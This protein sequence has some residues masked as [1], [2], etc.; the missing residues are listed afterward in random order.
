MQA[1]ITSH[2]RL[3]RE[4]DVENVILQPRGRSATAAES[5]PQHREETHETL[6]VT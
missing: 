3:L 6:F 5:M 2:P 1:D 4:E